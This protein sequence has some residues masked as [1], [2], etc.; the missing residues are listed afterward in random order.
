[1]LVLSKLHL[2]NLQVPNLFPQRSRLLDGGSNAT[3][4]LSSVIHL[5]IFM[6]CLQES[7][8]LGL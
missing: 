5:T 2:L 4:T 1:M 8:D 6:Q 3:R 7:P